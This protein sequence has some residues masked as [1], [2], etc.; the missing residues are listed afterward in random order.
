VTWLRAFVPNPNEGL[1]TTTDSTPGYTTYVVWKWVTLDTSHG[2]LGVDNGVR[3]IRDAA[4]SADYAKWH[5]SRHVP[6][7]FVVLAT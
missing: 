4:K 2:F 3:L 1:C 7:R 6:A 5:P